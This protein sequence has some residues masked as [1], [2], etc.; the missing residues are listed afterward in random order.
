M[1][2]PFPMLLVYYMLHQEKKKNLEA[3]FIVTCF[4]SEYWLLYSCLHVPP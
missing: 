3:D 4:L 1:G 2:A